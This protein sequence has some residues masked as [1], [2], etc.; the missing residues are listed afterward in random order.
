MNLLPRTTQRRINK[1]PQIPSVWE[2]DRRPLSSLRTTLEPNAESGGECVI[3]VDGSEGC[4]RAMEVVSPEMGPEAMVRTLLRAIETPQ[5]PA[6]PA[7]PRK[8]IVRDRETQFFL[9]G[10]LQD[11]DIA[12][13]YV[14]D[15]PLIDELFRGFEELHNTRPPA[16]PST[17]EPSLVQ[18]ARELWT[19]SPWTLLADY[20]ILEI[21]IDRWDL[22]P[23]YACVM[24]MLGREYG[25]ILY[26]SLASLKQFRQSA[27]EEKSM[28]RLEKAFLSQDC[29]FLS[30]ELADEEED[31]DEEDEEEDYDLADLPPSDIHP[32]FGSVHPYEGIRPYLDEEEARVVYVA[33]TALNRF[34]KGNQAVLAEESIAELHKRFRIALEA[35]VPQGESVSVTVSTMPGLCAE[36]IKLLEE[37]GTE[38]FTDDDDDEAESVLKED[39]VPDNAHLSLGM[40]PWHFL[41]QIRERPKIYHQA[42]SV[43]AGGEG[44]PVVMI[45]TSRPKAKDIIE[46]IQKSGGLEAIGF[47]P[48]EDPF[49]ETRYDLGVLKMGNGDL[50]LFGEFEEDDPDHRK[51]RRNWN[52]RTQS[53]KGYCGLIIAMGVT[54]SSRGNPQLTDMLALFETKMIDT[55]DLDLGVLTLLP[56]FG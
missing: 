21:A 13:D 54:G 43:K 16:L 8:I 3:W 36:F 2:G 38:I 14:P 35:I 29:W 50:Y 12:I 52:R 45:Q 42:R 15:L 20:D 41:D 24:G 4:V 56:H 55:K 27:L 7:R 34:F 32:V 23:L 9:R 18:T 44:F 10:V 11:L 47:N 5:N 49:D 46:K 19:S 17:W 1:I 39:L 40:V 30:Y 53:T 48:G 6:R 25:V 31:E 28:E 33:L 22:P 37:S 26:R 51:A